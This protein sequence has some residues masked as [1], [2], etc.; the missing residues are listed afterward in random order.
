[1]EKWLANHSKESRDALVRLKNAMDA[2]QN[3]PTKRTISAMDVLVSY[4]AIVGRVQHRKRG[5]EHVFRISVEELV[6]K[7]LNVYAV[8][9]EFLRVKEWSEALV[10]LETTGLFSPSS[11]ITWSE[12]KKWQ[13]FAYLVQEHDA[14]AAALRD[15]HRGVSPRFLDSEFGKVITSLIGI[16][17]NSFFEGSPSARQERTLRDLCAWFRQPPEE[18]SSVEWVPMSHE[19]REAVWRRLRQLRQSSAILQFFLPKGALRPY[20]LIRPHYTLQ[21]IAAA[22]YADRIH[23]VEYRAC[24]MCKALFKVGAHKEKKY[25]DRERCKNRAHQQNRRANAREKKSGSGANIKAKK[26]GLQ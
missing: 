8:R 16:D 13:R 17:A 4:V 26:G 19:D 2:Y 21:A 7:P 9:D 10:F 20:L 6:E 14:L 3:A 5:E 15:H 1:M 12:F 23:G 24:E 25:C 18:A 11:S 22:I